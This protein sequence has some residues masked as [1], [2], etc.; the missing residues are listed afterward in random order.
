MSEKSG[1]GVLAICTA[2]L[3]GAWWYSRTMPTT[4][5]ADSPVTTSMVLLVFAIAATAFT[6]WRLLLALRGGDA[7]SADVARTASPTISNDVI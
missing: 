3:W 2:F 7:P 4:M 6:M 1:V 5:S